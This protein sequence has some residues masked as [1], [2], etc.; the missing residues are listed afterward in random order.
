MDDICPAHAELLLV[1][2]VCG[3]PLDAHGVLAGPCGEVVVGGEG[4]G[5]EEE[6]G[7]EGEAGEEGEVCGGGE[8]CAVEGVG[9][10]G[11]GGG[12]REV[13]RGRHHPAWKGGV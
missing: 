3:D 12:D 2:L 7:G 8:G 13:F 11:E 6:D 4:R 5:A 10:G 1:H 9:V